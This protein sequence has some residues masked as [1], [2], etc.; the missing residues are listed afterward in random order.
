[1]IQ[2]AQQPAEW[3]WPVDPLAY[4]RRVAFSEQELLELEQMLGRQ[5]YCRV[6]IAKAA[7][8]N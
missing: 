3:R 6:I 5:Y 7:R 8:R 1:M 2:R 4:E